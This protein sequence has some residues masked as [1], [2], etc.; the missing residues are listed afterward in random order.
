MKLI[1]DLFIILAIFGFDQLSKSY[2]AQRFE[3]G[4]SITIINNFFNITYV[5][6]DGAG[7]SILKGQMTLFYVISVIALVIM[8][9]YLYKEKTLLGRIA[10]LFLIGGTLGNFYDRLLYKSVVDFLDFIIFGYDYPVFNIA[11]TFLTIGVVLL[12]ISVLMENKNAKA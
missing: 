1:I 8:A 9:Y 11:D 3:L 4:E 2:I 6:N 12:I 5:R 10:L 7:F